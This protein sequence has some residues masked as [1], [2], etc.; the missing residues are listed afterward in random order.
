MVRPQPTDRPT[1]Q[2]IERREGDDAVPHAR[3]L[4]VQCAV[5]LVFFIRDTMKLRHDLYPY[6][7]K[8]KREMALYTCV[9]KGNISVTGFWHPLRPPQPPNVLRGQI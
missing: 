2:L 8:S 5:H 7:P 1:E 6:F 4:G 3:T 9:D